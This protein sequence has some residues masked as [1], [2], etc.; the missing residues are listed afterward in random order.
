MGRAGLRKSQV[1]LNA[2]VQEVL[3]EAQRETEGRQIDW[4][5]APLPTVLADHTMLKQVWVN[6]ISNAV[7]Y[8][9]GRDRARIEIACQKNPASEWQF[10]V[11]DNGAG[12]DMRYADKLFGVFQRLH[13]AEEFEGTGIGLANVRRIVH[14]HGGRTWADGK[15]NEGA[16]FYFTLPA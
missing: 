11:Q 2:L 10:S 9:R 6:L 7:K 8:T 13:R 5:I 16:T 12:F 4:E 3:Q 14:R 15:V 1:D